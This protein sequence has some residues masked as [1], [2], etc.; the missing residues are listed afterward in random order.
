MALVPSG[1]SNNVEFSI[2]VLGL[3]PATS[4]CLLAAVVLSTTAS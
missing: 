2:K 1:V 3:I 4:E